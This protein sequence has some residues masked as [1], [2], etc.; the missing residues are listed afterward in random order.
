MWAAA[1]LLVGPSFTAAGES[2]EA[3]SPE[4]LN[5]SIA[6]V[7]T[8]GYWR[9]D[10]RSGV[11]R[12]VA[13]DVGREHRR[14]LVYVQWLSADPKTGNVEELETLAVE[15]LNRLAL[16]TVSDLRVTDRSR[17]GTTV[18]IEMRHE[19]SEDRSVYRVLIGTPKEYHLTREV[20][21][22]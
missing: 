5:P 10:Q 17:E 20:P 3:R 12:V 21:D 22:R 1:F 7:T 4:G 15:E 19:F 16:S 14:S 11:H 9:T 8:G 13:I 6:E 2:A 18:R